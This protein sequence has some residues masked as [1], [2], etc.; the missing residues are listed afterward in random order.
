MRLKLWITG[1]EDG[2]MTRTVSHGS[3]AKRTA[4]KSRTISDGSLAKSTAPKSRTIS[5]G[6]RQPITDPERSL[7][8]IVRKTTKSLRIDPWSTLS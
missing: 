5:H 3:L 7:W 4:P 6:L 8:R 2:T 1:K